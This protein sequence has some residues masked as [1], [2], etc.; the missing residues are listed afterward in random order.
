MD[1]A[2]NLRWGILLAW[3]PLAVVVAPGILNAFRGITE[4]KAT[5]LGAVAANIAEVMVIWG[6]LSLIA[7]EV[8]S[9]VLLG[10][11]LRAG[12]RKGG[13]VPAVASMIGAVFG[14]GIVVGVVAL[15]RR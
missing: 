2:K 11:A 1:A 3:A 9:L 14:L 13:V 5:G 8:A 7:V 12:V 6:V 15:L 4:Q 10:R